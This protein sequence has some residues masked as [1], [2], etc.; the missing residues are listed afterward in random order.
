MMETSFDPNPWYRDMIMMMMVVMM[1][2]LMMVM[3]MAH[4]TIT[5]QK[6][7]SAGFES[8]GSKK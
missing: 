6:N 5:M 3:L 7:I 2:L 8:Y 1:V 4:V